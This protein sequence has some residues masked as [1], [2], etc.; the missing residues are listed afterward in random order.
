MLFDYGKKGKVKISMKE[1]L[2]KVIE[3]FPEKITKIAATPAT[4][5][6]YKVRQDSDA[7]KLDTEG[8][9]IPPVSCSTVVHE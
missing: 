8:N 3:E 7:K 5:N 1:Y 6:L 2:R 4:E 9:S